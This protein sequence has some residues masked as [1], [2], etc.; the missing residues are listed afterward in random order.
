[1]GAQVSALI[2][3]AQPRNLT[4]DLKLLIEPSLI[5]IIVQQRNYLRPTKSEREWG[6]GWRT[7]YKKLILA[8]R[9]SKKI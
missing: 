9:V 3:F 4:R 5:L 2:R 1:M 6:T 7:T 8:R